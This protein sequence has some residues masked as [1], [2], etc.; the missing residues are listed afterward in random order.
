MFFRRRKFKKQSLFFDLRKSSRLHRASDT[1]PHGNREH[2]CRRKAF[3]KTRTSN[4][5]SFLTK[6]LLCESLHSLQSLV[7]IAV[8]ESHERIRALL[9]KVDTP[10]VVIMRHHKSLAFPIPAEIWKHVPLLYPTPDT[11]LLLLSYRNPAFLALVRHLIPFLHVDKAVVWLCNN[12]FF[13][14]SLVLR[15]DVEDVHLLGSLALH[16]EQI[17]V[18]LVHNHS[19]FYFSDDMRHDLWEHLRTSKLIRAPVPRIVLE[20]VAVSADGVHD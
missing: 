4:H 12:R 20:H 1:E 6:A 10:L 16:C 19:H 11:K 3:C 15:D 7:H 2:T 5:N 9:R 18:R 14:L 17:T 8:G 13:R